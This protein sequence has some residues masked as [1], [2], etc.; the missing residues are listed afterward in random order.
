MSWL[1]ADW[2]EKSF[3]KEKDETDTRFD[4]VID[5]FDKIG[6]VIDAHIDS[7]AD[8]EEHKNDITKKLE[9][10]DQELKKTNDE[11]Q[12]FE[13]EHNKDVNEFENNRK[14]CRYNNFGFCNNG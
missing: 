13:V 12:R 8:M 2:W 3:D 9:A 6:Q 5:R 11:I 14:V 10:I 4:N 7:I 1:Q